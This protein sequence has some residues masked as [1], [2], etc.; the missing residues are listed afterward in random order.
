[1]EAMQIL[2]TGGASRLG[3]AVAG[4]L[5]EQGHTVRA[6]D[7][8]ALP[9]GAAPGVAASFRQ[10]ELTEAEF[11]AP[12]LEGVQAI[13]H[14]APLALAE[15]GAG[16]PA[17][18]GGSAEILD[19]AARGTHV[20]LK[21]A[22]ERG[23]SLAV[24]GSTLAVMDAY[25]E[26]LEVTEQWRP[27]PRPVPEVLAPYLAE[28]TAREFTRDVALEAPMRIV[29]LRFAQLADPAASGVEEAHTLRVAD[30]TQAVLHALR[31]LLEGG[32]PQGPRPSRASAGAPTG[33]ERAGRGGRTASDSGRGGFGGHRWQLYHIASPR[34]EARYTS[35]AARRALGYGEEDGARAGA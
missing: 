5:V 19:A 29:C 7:G 16:P 13:V 17:G 2:L 22:V 12:L 26:E 10:G 6:T 8:V 28:L 24:Q 3:V 25:D 1:M 23:I 14:L 11:V 33:E 35:A 34:P 31:A 4:A 27:R 20:L 18:G 9:A 21:G 32:S 15:R 30:A